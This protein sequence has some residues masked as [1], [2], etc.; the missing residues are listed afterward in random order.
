MLALT[1]GFVQYEG[2]RSLKRSQRH[3]GLNHVKFTYFV[4]IWVKGQW[5][6]LVHSSRR[7]ENGSD[8]TFPATQKFLWNLIK[9]NVLWLA[10]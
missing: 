1:K 8:V 7:E 10:V 3:D 4:L 2:S 9:K 6:F 5:P